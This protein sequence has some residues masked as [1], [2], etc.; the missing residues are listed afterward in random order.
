[1]ATSSHDPGN[2]TASHAAAGKP[3][4]SGRRK[5]IYAL[6]VVAA[7]IVGAAAAWQFAF[8]TDSYRYR[9]RLTVSIEIDGQMHSGSSV[10][11]VIWKRQPPIVESGPFRASI[12][13]QAAFIDLEARG[14]VVA[15]LRT[16]DA[17]P[18]LEKGPRDVTWI[19]GR[20]FGNNSTNSELPELPRLAGRRQLA[21]DNMPRLFWFSDIAD[22]N[23]A[24]PFL[25]EDIQTVFDPRGRLEA[26]VEITR[27]PIVIDV[28]KKL[29]WFEKLSVGSPNFGVMYL[30]K[31]L[32][33]ARTMFI[34]DAS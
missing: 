3:Q 19:A 12:A 30:P 5:L 10:I 9:Y 29:P 8:S 31:G 33:L 15:V 13:G 32:A 26:Y 28:D 7:C 25:P 16:G 1:M 23:T 22:P 24:R 2:A 14:A 6:G 34:G 4:G 20:A 18:D 11:E 21:P 27:V 17:S